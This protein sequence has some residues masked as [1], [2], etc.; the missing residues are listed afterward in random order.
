LT[1]KPKTQAV[2]EAA[3]VFAA[4]TPPRRKYEPPLFDVMEFLRKEEAAVQE[5]IRVQRE[6][7][8]SAIAMNGN[9]PQIKKKRR[10]RG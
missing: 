3:E 2:A 8:L 1:T 9:H 4:D 6:A 5:R 7:R 10:S